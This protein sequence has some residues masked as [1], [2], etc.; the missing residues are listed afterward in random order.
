[1]ASAYVS[2]QVFLRAPAEFK[3]GLTHRL[4]FK[5]GR[6]EP[7]YITRNRFEIKQRRLK[8]SSGETVAVRPLLSLFRLF[9][10]P[11]SRWLGRVHSHYQNQSSVPD[12]F[13][14]PEQPVLSTGMDSR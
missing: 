4:S 2:A 11:L 12:G 6:R 1:M 7:H 14:L 9:P 13:S 3:F 5:T 8:L 10:H